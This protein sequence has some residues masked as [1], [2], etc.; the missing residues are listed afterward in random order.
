MSM[1][2]AC[3]SYYDQ[4]EEKAKREFFATYVFWTVV[5]LVHP[6][7]LWWLCCMWSPVEASFPLWL[8]SWNFSLKGFGIVKRKTNEDAAMQF[9]FLLICY[10][11]KKLYW[12]AFFT[13]FNKKKETK[14]KYTA[15]WISWD[16]MKM[17]YYIWC[18][19]NSNLHLPRPDRPTN[20]RSLNF[21]TWFFIIAVAFLSSPQKFSSFPA[22][23]VTIVPSMTSPSAITLKAIGS[24][25]LERQW[26]GRTVQMRLGL[27]VRTS[28]PP[29][30]SVIISLSRRSVI[31]CETANKVMI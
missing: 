12:Y 20:L 22:R 21:A 3:M 5:P 15:C 11:S 18:H 4:I 1:K 14:Q 30:A 10:T 29:G 19:I 13:I 7:L 9:H 31:S 26:F 16:F 8:S 27:P 24:V 25:L 6:L 17:E 23:T 2:H 28:S